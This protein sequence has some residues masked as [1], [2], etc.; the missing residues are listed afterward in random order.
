MKLLLSFARQ[1]IAGLHF[2]D[3][4]RRARESN[5]R[6]I[7]AIIN[8]LGEHYTSR[9][10]VEA[11]V[12][13]YEN[14]LQRLDTLDACISIKLSQFGL[15]I[16][17]DY[18][19]EMVTRVLDDCR[20]RGVFLWMDMEGSEYTTAT[21]RIYE[22]CLRRYPDTGVALQANLR[23]TE[24]DLR[25]LLT[26]RGIIR[27]CKGA[28][29][30]P[31]S[32]AFRRKRDVDE[33]YRRLMRILFEEGDRFALATHDD[34]MVREGVALQESHGRR[35]EFQM[36]LGVRDQLKE[37]LRAAGYRVLEYIPYGPMWLPY[38]LRRIRERPRNV[39]TIV[40]SLVSA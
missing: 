2:E 12:E 31:S 22:D 34:G 24:R 7:G 18:C 17:E 40:R 39:V 23:R 8:Y 16:D 3:G 27:L 21:L 20:R 37:E 5:S 4:L 15:T 10:D 9:E 1:W 30:E 11:A 14:I 33:N 38:F 32:I 26:K 6:G 36:L 19:M 28:Y 25:S 35:M 29:R 13:E